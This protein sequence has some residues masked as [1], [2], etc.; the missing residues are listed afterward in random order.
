MDRR[1]T[2]EASFHIGILVLIGMSTVAAYFWFLPLGIILEGV[3]WFFFAE[4]Q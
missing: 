1:Q 4:W 3:F 2:L